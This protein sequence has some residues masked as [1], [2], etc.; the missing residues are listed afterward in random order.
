MYI[1]RMCTNVKE[2]A[3]TLRL[4]CYVRVWVNSCGYNGQ[5][6][7]GRTKG[8]YIRKLDNRGV[9]NHIHM[10]SLL[11]LLQNGVKNLFKIRANKSVYNKK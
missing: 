1:R 2:K 6:G 7:K 9:G 10:S 5:L 8:V 3:L 4:S 11:P